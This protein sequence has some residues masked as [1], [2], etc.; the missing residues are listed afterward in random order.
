MAAE[1]PIENFRIECRDFT[2]PR[3]QVRDRRSAAK[4]RLFWIFQRH[5]E[6][7]LY[8]RESGST[9]PIWKLLSENGMG[10][11]SFQVNKSAVE[12]GLLS[13]GEH[14]A[15]LACFRQHVSDIDPSSRGRIRTCTMLPLATAAAVARGFGRCE[16]STAFLSAF[17]QQVPPAWTMQA[18]QEELA[19]NHERDLLLDEQLEEHGDVELEDM[20]FAEELQSMA[21]FSQTSEDEEKM[22][23]YSIEPVPAPLKASMER[24]V[25]NRTAVFAARRPGGAARDITA[26]GDVQS[27]Y[28]FY[29]WMQRTNRVPQGAFL[30]L[31]LLERADLG[32]IVQSYAE[33]LQNTQ[34]LRFSSI[35]NYLNGLASIVAYVYANFELP[36]ATAVLDPS[37]LTMILNLRSQAEKQSATQQ[38]FDKRVGAWCSWQ[39]VQDCRLRAM[40]RL[41]MA[42]AA[43]KRAFC[44][45]AAALSM[46]SLI[47]PDRVGVIRKLRFGHTLK[48][49]EGGGWGLDLRNVRD[50]HKTSRFYGPFAAKLPSALDDVLGTYSALLVLEFGGDEAYLFHPA[51]SGIDRPMESSNWTAYIKRLFKKFVD[52]EIVPKTLRSI[53]VTWLRENTNC[54]EI[55]KSA[56]HAM[57][58]RETTNESGRYDQNADTKLVK[59]AYDFNLS[60]ALGFQTPSVGVGVGAGGSG[61][62]A[63]GSAVEVAHAGGWE[64]VAF[65][66]TA[67]LAP[68]DQQPDVSE[69]W[70]LFEVKVPRHTLEIGPG[71]TVRF[72]VVAGADSAI[73]FKVPSQLP[74]GAEAWNFRLK[75]SKQGAPASSVSINAMQVKRADAEDEEEDEHEHEEPPAAA[76]TA[77]AAPEAAAAIDELSIGSQN[78]AGPEPEDAAEQEE[79]E[80]AAA[81]EEDAPEDAPEPAAA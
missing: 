51:N 15:I 25:A 55:L 33:W 34:G 63:G 7:V 61:S 2:M 6:R 58:H 64:N 53:F 71:D 9:G 38:M 66:A 14:D 52:K 10:R 42:N 46:L 77:A 60:F 18:Q 54:P 70:R 69:P 41:G 32:D 79:E 3:L 48:K 44:K 11:T 37:P 31:S 43:N 56:A 24:Y 39:D 29:G 49:L 59:A 27:L 12:T 62:G 28:R 80:E 30:W 21:K 36:D 65:F 72:P 40:Q 20:S 67:Y 74:E 73:V 75:L 22:R 13:Q 26:Q 19:A 76:P 16:A 68:A 50:S 4:P 35:A 23:R 57:K 17:T 78:E 81:M 5:L 1:V 47:P 45:D 8:N